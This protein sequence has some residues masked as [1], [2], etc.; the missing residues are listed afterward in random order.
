MPSR[1]QT[2]IHAGSSQAGLAVFKNAG[3]GRLMVEALAFR[4]LDPDAGTEEGW[5]PAMEE[6]VKGL[7][8]ARKPTGPVHWILPGARVLVK[9]LRIPHVEPAKRRQVLAFE[10]QQNLPYGLEALYW[11][12]QV[13]ADDGI[14]TEVV[15]LAARRDFLDGFCG[16][17]E[18]LSV[19]TASIDAAPILDGNAARHAV[20]LA[21]GPHLVVNIGAR[22]TNLTFLTPDGFSVRN[23]AMGGNQLTQNLADPLGAP[24]RQAE[25]LKVR[26]FSNPDAFSGDDARVQMM[27]DQARQFVQR[28]NM[29]ITR[30]VLTY[31][32]QSGGPGPV[33]LVLTGRGCRL[34]GLA[35]ALAEQQ[36]LPAAVLPLAQALA[37][38]PGLAPEALSEHELQ[39]SELAGAA[40]A[41]LG[42]E[43]AE[44]GA[45]A[46]VNLLPARVR[47]RQEL[48]RKKPVFL[49]AAAML[50]VAPAFPLLHLRERVDHLERQ[51]RRLQAELPTRQ[52]L[53]AEMQAT[54]E[55]I[56]RARLDVDRVDD[57]VNARTNW[58]LFF[59]A[60][61]ESLHD[62][63]DV[64]LDSLEVDTRTREVMPENPE[65]RYDAYGERI[66]PEPVEVTTTT[67]QLTGALLLRQTTE[68]GEMP[69][70]EDYDEAVISARIRSLIRQFSASPFIL[71]AGP[72]TVFWTRLEDGVLPFSFNLAVN[73][74]R[75]L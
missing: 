40:C 3:G 22:S 44:G 75:P 71:E 31:R 60:L 10:A 2:F 59:E 47:S 53:A 24:F 66:P 20:D 28:L 33:A 55:A 72:P 64:W 8:Q 50:A 46:G 63:G 35:E 49:A 70:G 58:I 74:R 51:G 38:G 21:A 26:F 48:G 1:S 56:A 29:E 11:D 61:Q 23:L 25:E 14:E 6:A 32:K 36:R 43:A 52:L 4:D 9:A 73:P 67:I 42:V 68:A 18:R 41:R 19:K 7:L 65:E 39:L 37:P 27:Q 15:L 17:M 12:S 5:L 13:L 30:S 69:V 54:L 16:A 57:L 62:V 34:P 45:W